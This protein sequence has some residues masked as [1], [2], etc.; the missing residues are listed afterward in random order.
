ML[1]K[2]IML[3]VCVGGFGVLSAEPNDAELTSAKLAYRNAMTT[4]TQH[5]E[6][7]AELQSKV[8]DLQNRVHQLQSELQTAQKQLDEAK[9]AQATA[10]QN[11][12]TT[13]ERLDAAWGNRKK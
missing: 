3:S 5:S 8:Q 13:G 2:I 6:S 11:L 1:R 10:Q 12:K 9:A 4:Y 7:V